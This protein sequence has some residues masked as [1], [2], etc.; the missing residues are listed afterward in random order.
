MYINSKKLSPY[1]MSY[2]IDY[3]HV[4]VTYRVSKIAFHHRQ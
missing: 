4:I 3:V 2:D 1:L